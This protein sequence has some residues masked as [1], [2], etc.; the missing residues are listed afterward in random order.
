[1]DIEHD[2]GRE[3]DRIVDDS[4]RWITSCEGGHGWCDAGDIEIAARKS[5]KLGGCFIDDGHHNAAQ[6]GRSTQL[7]RER[8]VASESPQL[9]GASFHESKGSVADRVDIEW[10]ALQIWP[11]DTGKKMGRR[12]GNSQKTSGNDG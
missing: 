9:A 12:I 3:Q 11:V 5:G 6:T 2:A 1:M 7:R 8:V 10:R 4:K